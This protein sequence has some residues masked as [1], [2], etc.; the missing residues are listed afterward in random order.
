MR[1]AVEHVSARYS[2]LADSAPS[3]PPLRGAPVVQ[4]KKSL[5]AVTDQGLV[6]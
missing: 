6:K 1:A 3:G 4:T 2:G 5:T